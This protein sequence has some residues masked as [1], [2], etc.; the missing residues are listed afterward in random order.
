MAVYKVIQDIEAD[1][2]FLG[3]L[4][5]K[6]FIFAGIAALCL[7]LGFVFV[8]R[9]L[10]VL[11]VLIA[12]ILL[13]SGFL[14]F[15]WGR[16]QPT[17]V[18]L[19]AKIRFLTKPRI[20]IWDQTGM[21]EL[22]TVTAP[23][24]DETQ[25]T[26]NL[27]QNEVRSRLRALADTIDSRGWAVKNANVNLYT[28]PVARP[29]P[30]T[31]D[32]LVDASM[33]P[34]EVPST[35]VLPSDDIMDAQNNPLAQHLDQMIQYS[36]ETHRQEALDRMDRVRSGAEQ[37]TNASAPVAT[38]T[39]LGAPDP[40][41]WFINQPDP[42]SMPAGYTTFA[43][44]AVAQPGQPAAPVQGQ[45]QNDNLSAEEQA[46]LDQIHKEQAEPVAPIHGHLRVIQPLGDSQQGGQPAATKT[47]RGRAKTKQA[48]EAEAAA[49]AAEEAARAQ[50]AAAAA[51]PVT[52]TPDPAILELALNNDRDVASL[53]RE[54]S[55][56]T[57]EPVDE[58]V[59]RLH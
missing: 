21:Q 45:Y 35:E 1:D 5:L 37:P 46:L 59:V 48:L 4:T 14:A 3:P 53:A 28:P 9:G 40:N 33:F 7:Y 34:Q 43:T 51:P 16:D 38:D 10:Y 19:M 58:V 56:K 6:Q 55:A 18:W 22:V 31:S 11:L 52:P 24:R 57:R 2:K 8:T 13:V 44:P 29:T 49:K 17:E 15:P 25:Y 54:A 30:A 12:P 42:A 41:Y 47:R 26:N 23:K 36:A 20:R 27:S 50:A 39:N 32:R